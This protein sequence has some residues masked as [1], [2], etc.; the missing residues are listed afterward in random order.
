MAYRFTNLMRPTGNIFR[1]YSRAARA[2]QYVRKAIL[3][4]MD[5]IY[6][7]NGRLDL[8][9]TEF[10][11]SNDYVLA[12]T[13]SYPNEFLAGVSINPQREMPLK[14][15]TDVPKPGQPSSKSFP[16]R[17]NSIREILA[18]EHFTESWP[19]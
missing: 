10:L 17:S 19:T 2:S 15:F 18:I 11:V 6:T 1:T 13:K 14:S 9:A 7:S 4:G 16:M 12:Q 8:N 5:G 3:L